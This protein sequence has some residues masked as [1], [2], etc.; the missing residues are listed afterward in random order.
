MR[1]FS[2]FFAARWSASS[3]LFKVAAVGIVALL[4]LGGFLIAASAVAISNNSLAVARDVFETK[5]R[6]DLAMLLEQAQTRH[7]QVRLAAGDLLDGTGRS[8]SGHY[9]LIDEISESLGVVAT[10]F[11]RDGDDFRRIATSIRTSDGSRA[12]GT[13]LG[14]DSAAYEPV[15]AGQTMV[16]TAQIL[17]EDYVT[18]YDPIVVRDGSGAVIGIWFLGISIANIQE[19]ISLGVRRS[20]IRLGGIALI[21]AGSAALL[22][23]WFVRRALL[24][25]RR[26]SAGLDGVARG[27]ADLTATLAVTS[28]DE[29]GQIS[30]SFNAFL[31]GLREIMS[32]IRSAT[33]ALAELGQELS[34]N[35]QETA[36]AVTEITANIHSLADQAG[37]QAG[38]VSEVTSTIEEISRNIE[39]LDGL[40]QNQ[41][42]VVAQSSASIEEMMASVRSVA[43]TL[44]KNVASFDE[45]TAAAREGRTRLDEMI[46]L[47]RQIADR[48]E[49]LQKTSAVIQ[50]IARQTNLLSMNAAIEAAHAGEFGRGFA[51]VATEIRSLSEDAGKQSKS[52][53]RELSDISSTIAR[54]AGSAEEV[55][56]AFVTVQELIDLV[57]QNERQI[58]NAMEEQSAGST[59]ILQALGEISQVTDAVRSG[60]GEI[61][62]ASATMLDEVVRIDGITRHLRQGMEEMQTGAGEIQGAVTAVEGLSGKTS[63]RIDQVR[64]LVGRFRLER[65]E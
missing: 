14:R 12:D 35:M 33:D 3:L 16:G 22:L 63:D 10:L 57:G 62:T 29:V 30:G 32:T 9:E 1:L 19:M 46:A 52:I 65:R 43:A 27:E 6:G 59:Q 54:A 8:L 48:S 17:G 7:G 51:V 15:V 53:G 5:L 26:V 2:H 41:S 38:S 45:L 39:G 18:I 64:T 50:A 28:R 37:V 55:S 49:G 56:Q 36:A 44:E 58:R 40:V 23:W 60:S 20:V 13:F 25:L 31:G 21:L 47:N 11:V 42:S 4:G 34:G 24:P 61:R